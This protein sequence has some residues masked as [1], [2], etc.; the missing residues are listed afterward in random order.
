M[1]LLKYNKAS[2][3]IISNL[4]LEKLVDCL[5]DEVMSN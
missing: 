5:E 3:R 1:L 2:N 4:L